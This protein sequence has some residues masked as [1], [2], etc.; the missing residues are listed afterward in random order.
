MKLRVAQKNGV[1]N[2]QGVIR[3][4]GQKSKLVKVMLLCYALVSRGRILLK[5]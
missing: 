4:S 5:P 2:V 1:Y 3:L